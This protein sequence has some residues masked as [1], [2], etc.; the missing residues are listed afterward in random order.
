MHFRGFI[1]LLLCR[2]SWALPLPVDAIVVQIQ[3]WGV[4]G[5]QQFGERVLFNGVSLSR[6][7]EVNNII[8]T[9]SAGALIP[10]SI[11]LNQISALK[12]H[13]ILRSRECILEGPQL[14]WTDRVFYDGKV[15][16]TLDHNDTWVAHVPHALALKVLWDQEVQRTKNERIHLQEG[17]IQ[18]M[19]ELKLSDQRSVLEIP[20]PQLLVPVLGVVAFFGLIVV[21]I[22]IYKKQGRRHPGGVI[23]SLI[24][25]PKDMTDTATER[26]PCGYR[27]L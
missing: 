16:L 5:G 20:L 2:L 4:V 18:L 8:K 3:Q 7:D 26:R 21:S 25:Y 23:G 27:T 24:H 10:A 13:T 19:K 17:C 12:D 6:S 22:L 14:H 15:Y 11:S 1:A 9:M